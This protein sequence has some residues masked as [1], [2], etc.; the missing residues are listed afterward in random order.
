[1]TGTE[2]LMPKST[3]IWLYDNTLLTFEQIGAFCDLD[4]AEVEAIADATVSKGLVS[5][6]PLQYGELTKEEIA[7][8]EADPEARLVM[9][10]N[11]LPKVK[12]R[13]KGPKYTPLSKRGD[14]PDAIA[15]M[16]KSHPEVTDA[17]IVKLVGTTKKTIQSIRERTHANMANIKPRHPA[18]IGLCTYTEFDKFLDKARAKAEKEGRY[19]PP[20]KEEEQDGMSIFKQ[21]AVPEVK[22]SGFDF[23]NFLGDTGTDS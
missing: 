3:A 11:D 7:K 9:A 18:D 15:Y 4:P 20:A 21:E 6:N 1:M 12:S 5:R 17:Q 16:V 23:S 10:K 22:K 19:T 8:C 13:S 2:L 14:K